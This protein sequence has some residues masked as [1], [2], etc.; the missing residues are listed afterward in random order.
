[1]PGQINLYAYFLQF[2]YNALSDEIPL[3]HLVY[4][5]H[6]LPPSMRSLVYDFGQLSTVTE[7]DYTRQ[8]VKNQVR[9][10]LIFE[11]VVDCM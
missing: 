5:V 1:M 9:K 8:I 3:R 6:D 4:R 7:E 2:E 11:Q 10:Q